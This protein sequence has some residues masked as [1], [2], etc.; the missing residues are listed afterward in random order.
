M[1]NSQPEAEEREFHRPPG[2]P[3]GGGPQLSN[4]WVYNGKA[5]DLSDWISR[6]PGGEF[7]IGRTKNRDITSI[8][9]SYH[10]DPER[11]GRMLERYALGRNA[12]PEDIHPKANAPDFLFKEG[13]DSWQDTPKYRF[14]NKDDLLH[15]VKARL[16]E[17]ELAARL[18]RMD[19]IFN[20]VVAVLAV[21][22]FAVQGL[23]L[24]ERSWMPLP[25]FIVLMVLLRSSL[26]GFGHYAIHRAQKGLNKI[27]TNTFDFNYVALAFVTADGHAL[28]HHPHTQSEVDIKKNVFTMMMRVPRLYRVPI[29]TLHKFGHTVTGMT[30][31]LLDVCR[32]TR[33]VGIKDMYGTWGG[34][35]PHFIGSFGV[36]ALLLGELVVFTLAGDFWAWAL[37]FVVTLWIS[38]FLVVASHDFEVET[39]ELPASDTED[40]AVHQVEQA[41]DLKVIGNRYVDC[42]LAAGLSSHRVHHVLPFQ[43]SGFANIATEDVLREESAK[44][45]IEWLPAKS[46]FTDRFPKLCRTYLLSPSREAEERNW[47]FIRE[48]CSP[49]ALKTCAVY[50][51]QGFTGI[52]T[53]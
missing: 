34:A 25:V 52:G 48:H 6:H 13:F 28:L 53:V 29:H 44:F 50:T 45:G 5:Y 41:Y 21:A 22:Y 20:L 15:K 39:E 37:Q 16:R 17:P 1:T 4:V 11:I 27:Y 14:D 23:R 18:R 3:P 46:F 40:W 2:P 31:R 38:T 49:G 47:G 36:R 30:I 43:R 19:T 12:L 33:K 8:I 7:F 35:L 32:L 10:R 51:V 9:G 42:F 24:F 26:A